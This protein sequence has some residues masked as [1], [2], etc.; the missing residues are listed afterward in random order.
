M[1]T[2]EDD[3][4][5]DMFTCFSHDWVM[6]FSNM[7]KVYR[8]KA[9]EIPE[10]SRVSKGMNIVNLLPLAADEKIMTILPVQTVEDGMYICMGTKK[11]IIKRTPL[12]AFKNIRKNGLIALS[13]DEDDELCFV[14]L[15]NG[16]CNLLV[17]TKKG[18]AIKFSETNVRSMGRTAR[19]VRAIRLAPG[20]MVIGMI[21]SNSDD[22][23][24]LTVTETGYGRISSITDYR[25]Q[26]RGG[27]GII[28]YRTEKYGDVAA[29]VLPGEEEDLIMISSSG[30]IIRISIDE[31]SIL[32]RPA[33]GVRVMRMKLE[34]DEKLLTVVTTPHDEDEV[35]DVP[36]APDEDSADV[37]EP[38]VEED[39]E[40]IDDEELEEEIL[41]DEEE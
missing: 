32:S 12:E 40:I 9:Y 8:M 35:T 29:V 33:K 6:M 41:E 26:S 23:K 24:V 37:G 30:V 13:I 15:T 34:N 28:N 5:E 18:K 4:V 39:E 36:D 16:K 1:T 11:G 14:H 27:K 19:G 2:R 3:V 20:D 10:G 31:L 17:A 38:E 25:L 22:D 21:V 7:G